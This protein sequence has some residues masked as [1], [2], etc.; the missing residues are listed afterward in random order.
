MI[1]IIGRPH[2][3]LG[4]K[5]QR[6]LNA[7]RVIKINMI[8]FIKYI[9]IYSKIYRITKRTNFGIFLIIFVAILSIGDCRKESV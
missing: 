5:P 8:L 4:A 9:D 3:V 6:N 2:P 1:N 7:E